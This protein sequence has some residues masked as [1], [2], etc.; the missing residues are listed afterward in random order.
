MLKKSEAEQQRALLDTKARFPTFIRGQP[1]FKTTTLQEGARIVRLLLEAVERSPER[2]TKELESWQYQ[3]TYHFEPHPFPEGESGTTPFQDGVCS[4]GSQKSENLHNVKSRLFTIRLTQGTTLNMLQHVPKIMTQGGH[5]HNEGVFEFFSDDGMPFLRVWLTRRDGSRELLS[6]DVAM[7][8]HHCWKDFQELA[9]VFPADAEP[10]SSAFKVIE[11]WLRDEGLEGF[12]AK[13]EEYL[14]EDFALCLKLQ[15]QRLYHPGGHPNPS[16]KSG[17]TFT[18]DAKAKTFTRDGQPSGNLSRPL[19]KFTWAQHG[20]EREVSLIPYSHDDPALRSPECWS[21]A[22]EAP[23]AVTLHQ[24]Y[25]ECLDRAFANGFFLVPGWD[26]EKQQNSNLLPPSGTSPHT[27]VPSDL[28]SQVLGPPGLQEPI[29]EPSVACTYDPFGADAMYYAGPSFAPLTNNDPA[30]F[31]HAPPMWQAPPSWQGPSTWQAPSM[32]QAPAVW[33]AGFA[34]MPQ[35]GQS[36]AADRQS[37]HWTP[38]RVTDLVK[39][40][41]HVRFVDAAFGRRAS[42]RQWKKDQGVMRIERKQEFEQQELNRQ[43]REWQ[44]CEMFRS[45][46]SLSNDKIV[47]WAGT[48]EKHKALQMLIALGNV[49]QKYSLLMECLGSLHRL[50]EGCGVSDE[51]AAATGCIVLQQFV[52]EADLIMASLECTNGS[53]SRYEVLFVNEV[54]GMMPKLRL[55]ENSKSPYGNHVVQALVLLLKRLHRHKDSRGLYESLGVAQRIDG[56]FDEVCNWKIEH[57]V[58]VAT[59]QYGCRVIQRMLEIPTERRDQLLEI[60]IELLPDL[61]I[62][63]FGNHAPQFIL[64]LD[65]VDTAKVQIWDHVAKNIKTYANHAYA[66]RIVKKGFYMREDVCPGWRELSKY[67][68]QEVLL[69]DGSPKLEFQYLQMVSCACS[70]W[71]EC[72]C[73]AKSRAYTLPAMQ[74]CLRKSKTDCRKNAEQIRRDGKTVA[75]VQ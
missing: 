45:I 21:E 52:Q 8:I 7:N 47:K 37:R 32:W 72:R 9:M 70:N 1:E 64:D 34:Q 58:E 13:M 69:E 35:T 63:E 23:Y 66:H 11:G 15:Y 14:Q 25:E 62:D 10:Q 67:M 71:R 29:Y 27:P 42:D 54:L 18:L 60:I 43:E 73:F 59:N 38:K 33:E 68:L 57:V 65:G 49:E 36:L 31:S 51:S 22:L 24:E 12:V 6:W 48:K 3:M 4:G 44:E 17:R 30:S 75:V 46:L 41:S 20:N 55:F 19:G 26:E 28:Y 50:S 40:I 2:F 53:M 61:C 74:L 5:S 56:L 39:K 16:R